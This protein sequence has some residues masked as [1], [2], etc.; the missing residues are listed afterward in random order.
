MTEYEDDEIMTAEEFFGEIEEETRP[1]RTC[2]PR[3]RKPEKSRVHDIKVKMVMRAH[4][5][6]RER[7]GKIVAERD[8][9]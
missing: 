6:S 4:G 2:R 9:A 5:V 8:R 1:S 7:A 3:V